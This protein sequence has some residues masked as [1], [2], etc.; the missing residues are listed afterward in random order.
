MKR[1]ISPL[2]ATVLLIGFVI[3][4]LIIIM[5]W[6]RGYI[7]EIKEKEGKISEQKLSCVSDI[8]IDIGGVNIVGNNLNVIIENKKE[9]IDGFTFRCTEQSGNIN[10]VN[11]DYGLDAY[12][13][14]SFTVVCSSTTKQVDII[15]KL[16]IGKGVYEPCSAQHVV[17]DLTVI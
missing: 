14:A 8:A 6:G 2:V 15:P 7:E 12:S 3:V 16:I 17:Y 5:L 9:K 10:I 11:L 1:G 4:L 13:I